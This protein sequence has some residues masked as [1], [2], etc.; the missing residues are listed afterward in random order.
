MPYRVVN[1]TRCSKGAKLVIF[2][3]D[4]AGREI[5]GV[6]KWQDAYNEWLEPYVLFSVGATLKPI[7]TAHTRFPIG[8]SHILSA[9]DDSAA[10][11]PADSIASLDTLDREH[12]EVLVDELVSI[13]CGSIDC[14]RLLSEVGA[15]K[16]TTL[17]WD[18]HTF[19]N[20]AA[21]V[22]VEVDGLAGLEAAR[23]IVAPCTAMA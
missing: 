13:A 23:F 8:R 6:T 21:S 20:I 5:C 22:L 15:A 3:N 17:G 2:Q 12:R 7:N 14:D 1:N 18:I 9:T 10:L 11:T 16:A 4:L 19:S